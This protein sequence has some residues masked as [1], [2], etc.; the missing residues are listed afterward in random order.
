M[1][2]MNSNMECSLYPFV[3]FVGLYFMTMSLW[4]DTNKTA[5]NISLEI[6]EKPNLIKIG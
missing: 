5:E 2:K 4:I 6:P 3:Y 1:T